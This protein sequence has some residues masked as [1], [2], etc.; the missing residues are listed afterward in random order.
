MRAF[1][2]VSLLVLIA[3]VFS[4]CAGAGAKEVKVAMLFPMTGG[5]A[6]FGKSSKEG[7]ELAVEEWNAKGGINGMKITTVLGD[8]RCDAQEARNQAV[9]V[10]DQDKVKFIIGEVCSSASIPVSEV[11]NPKKVLQI[12]PTSTNPKVTVDANGKHKPYTFRACFLD[13][14]QGDVLAAFAYKEKGLKTAA[15]LFDQGNDY[16]RG[17]AEYIKAPYEKLGGQ[18]KVYEAYNK[19]DSDFSAIL[20]KVADAKVDVLFLPDYYNKVSLI[21]KQ[22]K[23]KGITAV[24]MGGDGWDSAE[25]DRTATDGSYFSNHYSPQDPRPIVQNF[26][27]TYKAKYGADPD[28]LAVLAY[29]AANFLFSAIQE[30]KSA[31]PEKVKDTMLKITVEGISGQIKMGPTGD[32]IKTAAI[33]QVKGGKIEFVKFAAP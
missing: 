26:L 23:D 9:K 4:S 16:V 3:M 11:A 24:M 30:T 15:I 18:V 31:D 32:P 19:D 27:K 20:A 8:S 13:P 17:L 25:L 7:V 10:I 6:T 2:F 21:A 29:D 12:S 1:K 33:S 5:E 22:A 14:F 28:A